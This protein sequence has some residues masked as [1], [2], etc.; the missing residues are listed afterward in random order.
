MATK[1]QVPKSSPKQTTSKRTPASDRGESP[2]SD[3]A[4]TGA[5]STAR[6]TVSGPAQNRRRT[7]IQDLATAKLAGTETLAAAFPYN[8]A[9]PSE[10]GDAAMTPMTGQTAEPPDPI[11][12]A[13]SLTETGSLKLNQFRRKP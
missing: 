3:P 10:L 4:Q 2:A 9:K 1:K 5:E 11:V 12:G 13:S 7:D 8:A 6:S